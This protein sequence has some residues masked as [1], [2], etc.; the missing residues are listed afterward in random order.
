[1]DN[2][3]TTKDK[4]EAVWAGIKLPTVTKPVY[5]IQNQLESYLPRTGARSLIEIGCAPGGWMAYFN[6]HF[7]YSVSGLEYAEA[8]A[9]ATKK[10]HGN[11]GNRR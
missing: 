11:A 5:D 9:E 2:T 6:N 4:W 8:A 3:M 10:K 1:M 7:S